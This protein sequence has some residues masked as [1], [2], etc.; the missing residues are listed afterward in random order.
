MHC[1]VAE[2]F[3]LSYI[4]RKQKTITPPQDVLTKIIYP[5]PPLCVSGAHIRRFTAVVKMRSS[6]LSLISGVV[7]LY[8]LCCCAREFSSPRDK[9]RLY[10][11]KEPDTPDTPKVL[12]SRLTYFPLIK[13]L[14]TFITKNYIWKVIP[15][16]LVYI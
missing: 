14:F 15:N 10:I 16:R 2:L 8:V 3:V 9:K 6:L 1:I 4:R 12:Q 11:K 7:A 13:M 5:L